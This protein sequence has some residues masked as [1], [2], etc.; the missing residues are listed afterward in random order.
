METEEEMI[1][2][3]CMILLKIRIFD[4]DLR[5]ESISED[6]LTALQLLTTTKL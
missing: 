1:T 4:D 6:I 3:V 2:A 5:K